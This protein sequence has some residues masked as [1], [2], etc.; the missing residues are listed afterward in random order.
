V[1]AFAG[2]GGKEEEV[3]LMAV[4]SLYKWHALSLQKRYSF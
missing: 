1:A 2:R 3:D 4:V